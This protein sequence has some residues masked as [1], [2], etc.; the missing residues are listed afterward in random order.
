VW[1]FVPL[2]ISENSLADKFRLPEQTIPKNLSFVQN[3]TQILVSGKNLTVDFFHSQTALS[4]REEFSLVA[5]VNSA[6]SALVGY[7]FLADMPQHGHGLAEGFVTKQMQI[8]ESD[9]QTVCRFQIHNA[10]FH[11]PGWWRF[12]VQNPNKEPSNENCFHRMILK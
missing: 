10:E 12:C 9:H 1:W 8:R 7:K 2:L 3:R 11:M 5:T 6:C 4:L